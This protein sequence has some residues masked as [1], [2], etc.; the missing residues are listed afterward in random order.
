MSTYFIFKGLT[1]KEQ[2]NMY[3]LKRPSKYTCELKT[4]FSDCQ[5]YQ[6]DL[7][8]KNFIEENFKTT[9]NFVNEMEENVEQ[10]KNLE[11]KEV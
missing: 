3:K 4:E 11:V 8:L 6:I 9:Q 7:Q 5:L 2:E 10:E 1:S